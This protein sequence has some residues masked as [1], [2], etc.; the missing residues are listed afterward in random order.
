MKRE[1]DFSEGNLRDRWFGVKDFWKE[2]EGRTV[3]MVKVGL[4]RA[5]VVE[6]GRRVGCGRYKRSPRRRGYRNGS[7]KRDLLTGMVG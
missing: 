4:E 2:M 7:C 5:L 3:G 1:L 6:Q